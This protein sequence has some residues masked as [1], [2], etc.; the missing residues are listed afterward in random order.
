MTTSAG[1]IEY[2]LARPS[3]A[4]AIAALHADSWRRTF[5]GQF[6]DAYLDNEAESDRAAVWRQRLYEPDP[7]VV[8]VTI[9]AELEGGLL[10]FVHSIVDEDPEWGTLLD[11]LHVRHDSRRLG[12]GKRL[13]AETGERLC[14]NGFTGSVYLWTPA[15]NAAAQRFYD[16]LDGRVVER[17]LWSAPDG[18]SLPSVRYWWP[19]PA[20]LARHLSP[21]REGLR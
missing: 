9:I 6:S 21:E 16:T 20:D 8:T 1:A 4:G 17:R 19:D 12:I 2:R 10:G 14:R 13:V 7:G 3:D 11:N 15:A 5:R 18:R